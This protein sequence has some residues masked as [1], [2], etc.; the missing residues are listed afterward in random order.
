ML[1]VQAL[2]ERLN[3]ILLRVKVVI[4]VAERE[5]GLLG[6]R[7][8]RRFLVTA[9]TKDLE[10]CFENERLGLIALLRLFCFLCAHR[11]HGYLLKPA[12][13]LIWYRFCEIAE[14]TRFVVGNSSGAASR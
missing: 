5:A 7:A 12:T 10:R 8:H 1:V 2:V 11:R 14:T 13:R 3:Q 6:D 4:G 9:F